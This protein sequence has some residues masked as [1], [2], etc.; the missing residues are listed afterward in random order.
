MKNISSSQKS[1]SYLM[2]KHE[3][4]LSQEQDTPSHFL[5]TIS[6]GMFFF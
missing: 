6:K 5:A 3:Q 1:A 4:Q 2:G